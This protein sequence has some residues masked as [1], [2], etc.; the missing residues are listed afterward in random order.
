MATEKQIAANRAN[1]KRSTGPKTKSGRHASSRNAPRHGLACPPPRNEFTSTDTEILAR[2]LLHEGADHDQL[3]AARQVAQAQLD[4][5]RVRMVRATLMAS[6][7]IVRG[8]MSEF[9]RL[10]V[11]DRYERIARAKRRM[12]SDRL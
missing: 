7:D 8:N 11:I 6:L 5:S 4:L 1:A 3:A 2:A 12:A 9:R 10:M